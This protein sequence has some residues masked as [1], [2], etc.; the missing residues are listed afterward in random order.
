MVAIFGVVT[1]IFVVLPA[2]L[3]IM[4]KHYRRFSSTHRDRV[5]ATPNSLVDWMVQAAHASVSA[6]GN[7]PVDQV[8]AKHLRM[9]EY[10]QRGAGEGRPRLFRI[11]PLGEEHLLEDM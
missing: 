1:L 2:H 9:W 5:S 10:G 11:R 4:F 3:A 6:N 8:K 7:G